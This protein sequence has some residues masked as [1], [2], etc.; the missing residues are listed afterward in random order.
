[1]AD[2]GERK[3]ILSLLMQARD[4]EGAAMQ[5]SE[6]RDELV[7]LLL[8]G[9]ETTATTVAW[10][11]ERL[12]RHPDK[13]ER[14][15]AQCEKGESDEYVQ[16]VVSET[17]RVRPVVPLVIRASRSRS[18]RR[19]RVARGHAGG[20]VDI[21]HQ[22]RPEGVRGPGGVPPG[23]LHGEPAGDVLVD[24]VRRGDQAVHRSVV[25]DA[26]GEADAQHDPARADA[27]PPAPRTQSGERSRRRAI[28]LV[29]ANG[30]RVV[31]SRRA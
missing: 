4:E 14:L 28:T 29:P 24:T 19:A 5:D 25:R 15:T 9:H 6:L 2:L 16:A 18:G 22:P 12:V 10:A 3:D 1:M 8:A 21:P 27:K 23:A 26:R 30:A 11:I 20:A 17:L 31:W 7:T 13:L